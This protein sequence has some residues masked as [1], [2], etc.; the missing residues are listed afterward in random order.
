[1]AWSGW[2]LHKMR[3]RICSKYDWWHRKTY[4]RMP[5]GRCM[6]SNH[7][8]LCRTFRFTNCVNAESIDNTKLRIKQHYAAIL[9]EAPSDNLITVFSDSTP[10]TNKYDYSFTIPEIRIALKTSRSNTAPGSN[11]MPTRVLQLCELE[12]DVLNVRNSHSILSNN[13]NTL[14][15]E[16][17]HIIIVSIPMKGNSSSLENQHGIAKSCA[18]A[19]LTNKLL[20]ARIRDII[21]PQL[22]GVQSGFRAGRSTVEQTMAL[23]YIFDMCRVSRRMTTIIFVDFNKAFDSIDRRAISVVLSKY[24]VSELLIA[25][26]KQFYIGT[27]AVVATAHEN[28]EKFSTTS[29]VLQGDTLAPFLYITLLDY[30]LRETLFDNIDGFTITPH[31]SSR[32][33]AVRIG[34]LVYADD[35]AI[36]CDTI[37]QAENV[38]WRLKMNASKV[39][40]KINLKKRRSCTLDTI[41]SRVQLQL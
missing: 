4:S 3:W 32:Y 28:N 21:E 27:Y 1:M 31:R 12:E 30:V 7:Y 14:P 5:I 8:F 25:N 22:L 10:L 29:G 36:T 17:K 38:L 37:D 34:A 35:I 6:E 15:N 23:C 18:F 2:S 19:K 33:P 9:H 11:G 24:G 20:L 41:L 13:D 26:V 40:I 16:L 39:G